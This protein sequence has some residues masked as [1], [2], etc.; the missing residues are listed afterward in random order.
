MADE[1]ER[2]GFLDD[3][4]GVAARGRKILRERDGSTGIEGGLK[5]RPG[6]D[7][8][9]GSNGGEEQGREEEAG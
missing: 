6:V 8:G 1:V 2:D 7:A 9:L 3:E 5:R 4:G